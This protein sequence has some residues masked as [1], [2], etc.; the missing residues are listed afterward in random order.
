MPTNMQSET[1][2]LAEQYH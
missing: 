1:D 2:T